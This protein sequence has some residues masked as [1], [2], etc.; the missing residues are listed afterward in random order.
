MKKIVFI[1][2]PDDN[3]QSKLSK[4]DKQIKLNIVGVLPL[5][6]KKLNS[7]AIASNSQFLVL[8]IHK[9]VNLPNGQSDIKFVNLIGDADASDRSLK[10]IE[11]LI[12][13]LSLTDIVNKLTD[14]Y[15]TSR[16]SLQLLLGN[17]DNV[18]VAASVSAQ[19]NDIPE[20]ISS[21]E[22]SQMTYPVIIRLSGFH[23][24]KYMKK[25]TT[26]H[27]LDHIKDWF[28][29]SNNFILMEYMVGL[30]VDGY[31]RKARITVID[32]EFYPQ[33][34]LSSEDWCVGVENRYKIMMNNASLRNDENIFLNSFKEEIYPK[35]KKPL[36]EI[37]KKIGLDIYGIDCFLKD[38]GEIVVFEANPCM[39]LLSMWLGPNKEYNYKIPRRAAVRDAI[40]QLL[41]S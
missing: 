17:I 23:N 19:V 35:Y 25:I 31:Y 14:V 37:H 2:G 33:H 1:T 18:R 5:D 22:N 7:A 40:V 29:I 13:D 15:K 30:T 27:E 6:L 28:S 11:T 3:G 10:A 26:E 12:N 16:L 34:L 39:D 38:N 41:S 20:L 21:I 8:G 36:Q 24:S 9:G 32:G 4:K